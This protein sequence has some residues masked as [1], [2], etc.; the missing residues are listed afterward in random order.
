MTR[1]ARNRKGFKKT[2]SSD[3]VT[4]SLD[5]QVEWIKQQ[6]S[7][8]FDVVYHL[9][10]SGSTQRCAL[11]YLQGMVDL[12]M[13]QD[14]VLRP[15]LALTTTDSQEFRERIFERKQLPVSN[16]RVTTIREGFTSLFESFVL[17]LIDGEERIIE[18]PFGSYE[19]RSI[20]EPANE[21][22]VRGPREA[23]I[24]S[25]EVNL[26]LIRKR[27]KTSNFKT[28]TMRLGTQT[29][30]ELMILYIHGICKKELVDE[31]RMKLTSIDIDGVLG[32]SYIEE[33]LDQSP[34]SPFPQ[35]Q[36][37]ERP[38]VVSAALL[39]GRVAVIVDGTPMVLL[40]PVTLWMLLQSAEDYY[41]RYVAG[42]WIRWIRYLFVFISLLL[43]SVYIAIT[44]FHPEMIPP[45]L[46][47]TIAASREIVPFPALIEAFIME[48]SFEAL[49]EAAVRIPKSIGQAVSII[50]ALIIGTAAVQAGI[51]SAAMVIIVSFTGIA[52]FIIPHFD[53]G[54][55]FRFLRFPIMIFA[56]LFGLFGIICGLL[57]IYIHL[58]NLR[59]FGTPYLA[60][61]T[62]FIV[63]DLKDTYVRAPWWYMRR[64]PNTAGANKIR[65]QK[66][67]YTPEHRHEENG[68]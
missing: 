42:T 39:E 63:S 12:K 44:T 56:G 11:V 49:R 32:S 38:D 30:T 7:D 26:S 67:K 37:S 16:Y 47:I 2:A 48:I 54:L 13:L 41:Q 24:E 61:M 62:P 9:F 35:V 10:V 40:A 53:L 55:S 17:L 28:E 15:L 31:V 5:E 21:A 64:R 59:S 58:I 33:F 8:R 68:D 65:Q 14:E 51:V 4:T 43:P 66:D 52:S 57:L 6:L 29:Q 18:L 60:P 36:Y 23:F 46:L 27:L 45:K 50:G 20:D 1:F 19:Q 34:F 3:K 25:A 22:T